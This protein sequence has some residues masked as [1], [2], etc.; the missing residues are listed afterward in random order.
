MSEKMNIYQKLQACRV[1][2]QEAKIKKS[3]KNNYSNYD[4][5]ELSDILPKINELMLEH[6]LTAL[7][8]FNKEEARLEIINTDNI[9]EKIIFSSPVAMAELKG[10][11]EI[12]NIGATQTYMRRYLYIMAFEIAEY[13]AIEPLTGQEEKQ[14]KKQEKKQ[15]EKK[16]EPLTYEKAS[17]IK[18][19]FG[20]YKGKTLLEVYEK[21]PD[22]VTW[23]FENGQDESIKAAFKIIDEHLNVSADPTT[24]VDETK[25]K[26]LKQMI[27]KTNTP[28]SEFLKFYKIEKLEDMTIDLFGRAMRALEKKFEKMP[29]KEEM[30]YSGTPFE[31]DPVDL[32]I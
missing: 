18:L 12:Q 11:H 31:D 28:E 25:L 26:A 16:E 3:G 24:L 10:C 17:G 13:D 20:K 32:P 2:F 27:I 21:H 15:D 7:F 23:F 30:D 9:E 6:G 14:K 5:F 29:K 19:D 4:Y 22:Y 1:K 8:F